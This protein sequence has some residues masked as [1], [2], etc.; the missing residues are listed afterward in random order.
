MFCQ[1]FF[2]TNFS[3][4]IESVSPDV[5]ATTGGLPNSLPII[6][7][8]IVLLY[9]STAITITLFV[10]KVLTFLIFYV[11]FDHLFYSKY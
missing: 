10:F 6:E 7:D 9:V 5:L 2:R 4:S 1:T 3:S 8:H 11:T